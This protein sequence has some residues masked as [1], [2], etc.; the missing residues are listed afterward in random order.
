MNEIKNVVFEK[1]ENGKYVISCTNT[2]TKVRIPKTPARICDILA[3]N[4]DK[5]VNKEKIV[6][7]IW[8]RYDYFTRRTFDVHINKVKSVLKNTRYKLRCTRG[9]VGIFTTNEINK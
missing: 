5:F 8:G 6:N 4:L 9:M 7:E 3:Q 2:K 1:Y